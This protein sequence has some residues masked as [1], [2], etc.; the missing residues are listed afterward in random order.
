MVSNLSRRIARCS[1][2]TAAA[3]LSSEARNILPPIAAIH[4]CPILTETE[5]GIKVLGKGYHRDCGGRLITGGEMPHEMGLAEAVELLLD[6]IAEY[7]FATA[8]GQIPG[9]RLPE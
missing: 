8:V 3:W 9:H 1:L 2:D 6:S 4:G 5:N 7:D